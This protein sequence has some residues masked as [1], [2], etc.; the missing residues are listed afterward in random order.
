MRQRDPCDNRHID[1]RNDYLSLA[2][3]HAWVGGM[4]KLQ[5]ITVVGLLGLSLTGCP[6]VP[7]CSP[8]PPPNGIRTTPSG[9]CSD[10]AGAWPSSLLAAQRDEEWV[11]YDA[12]AV[13]AALPADVQS[14]HLAEL[15]KDLSA[16]DTADDAFINA[17]NAGIAAGQS[18]F[19]EVIQKLDAAMT[20]I[21]SL[22]SGLNS[23]S[24]DSAKAAAKHA[25]FKAD[26]AL[27]TK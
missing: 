8:P 19:T 25:D 14:Q 20:D 4:N 3:T 17:V 9:E 1:R 10:P 6:K 22:V 2:K 26:S 21:V 5:L 18:N 15:N 23:S 16:I 24:S 7:P 13:F 12:L 27:P 11:V